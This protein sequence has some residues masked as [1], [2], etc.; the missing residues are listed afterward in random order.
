MIALS[1][2]SRLLLCMSPS[3]GEGGGTEKERGMNRWGAARGRRG[4][5]D[6]L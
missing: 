1:R 6:S 2:K 5:K 4:L 3:G